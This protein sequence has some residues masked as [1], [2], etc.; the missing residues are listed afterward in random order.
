MRT[1][2][3]KT[4]EKA[5]SATISSLSDVCGLGSP[6]GVGGSS[7]G[8]ARTISSPSRGRLARQDHGLQCMQQDDLEYALEG[9]TAKALT[10]V[11]GSA[12]D[13]VALCSDPKTRS[14]L[15]RSPGVLPRVLSTLEA[16]GSNEVSSDAMVSLV[17]SGLM[18][19]L[20]HGGGVALH[21]LAACLLRRLE[22]SATPTS[23]TSAEPP[24]PPSASQLSSVWR[25]LALMC[26]TVVASTD[27]VP[28][29]ADALRCCRRLCILGLA[30]CARSSS[31][32]LP[33]IRA[34][35]SLHE[36]PRLI[37]VRARSERA[38]QL[39]PLNPTPNPNTR[40]APLTPRLPPTLRRSSRPPRSPPAP[41]PR[42]TCG[43][44]GT[45]ATNTT[46]TSSISTK[47]SNR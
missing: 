13:I 43:T 44:S 25:S 27:A 38:P 18:H 15:F 42:G 26:P 28:S 24:P 21:E 46:T 19:V 3:R 22:L 39:P 16:A 40:R 30:A 20:A 14:P 17:L 41:S 12:A 23:T 7:G 29:D 6:S 11:R 35:P 9:L 32:A 33:V 34:H 36:V 4:K 8:A 37:E 1:F 5:P 31:A 10:V 45:S 2:A 47:S